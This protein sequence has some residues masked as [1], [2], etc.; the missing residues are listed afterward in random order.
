MKGPGNDL[1]RILIIA[2][3]HVPDISRFNNYGW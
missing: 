1:I 3:K 2:F